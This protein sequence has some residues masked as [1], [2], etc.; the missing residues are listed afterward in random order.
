MQN[1][2]PISP[3]DPSGPSLNHDILYND[4]D[5]FPPGSVPL[6]DINLTSTSTSPSTA[7]GDRPE[8]SHNT[9]TQARHRAKR[10]AYIEQVTTPLPHVT[11]QSF[12]NLPS[13]HSLSRP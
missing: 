1:L 10:K 4:N 12:V 3:H 13:T 11:P 7:S 2:Q 6:T 9:K 8:R 5:D